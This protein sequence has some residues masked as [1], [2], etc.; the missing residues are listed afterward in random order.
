MPKGDRDRTSEGSV[1]ST[2]QTKSDSK[3]KLKFYYKQ[4]PLQPGRKVAFFPAATPSTKASSAEVPDQKVWMLAVVTRCIIQER[5]K[6]SSVLLTS[7]KVIYSV[8]I[9][10]LQVRGAR[11]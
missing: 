1:T 11:R 8:L 3:S 9:L 6:F 4:F 10:F 7:K 5:N 2:G